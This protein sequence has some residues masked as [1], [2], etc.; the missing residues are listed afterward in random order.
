MSWESSLEYYR[1]INQKVNQELGGLHSAKAILYS[2]DF[3]EIEILQ[4]QNRW[5]ELT[6]IMID[7]AQTL[8]K[9]GADM[10][11]ICT[12]T[13]HK[14]ADDIQAAVGIPLIHIADAAA[15]SIKEKSLKKA[16]LLGTKFTMEEDFYKQRLLS[17]YGIE[18]IIPEEN[19]REIVHK[20][21]Y[22]ELCRGQ[23]KESS[24][25]KYIRI[26]DKLVQE[27]AEGII[28]GCTEI[29]LLVKQEDI[30]VPVFNTMKIHGESAVFNAIK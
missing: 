12:N 2:V 26:I 9:A 30:S 4:H 19:D 5:H 27:G 13:M 23:I 24:R 6:A 28:L 7:A 18:V 1:I 20:I 25:R 29:P 21:I 14:T 11:L 8:E 15:E 16:G 17:R 10:I 22:T 3:A